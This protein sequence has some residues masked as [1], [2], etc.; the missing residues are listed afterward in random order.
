MSAV[1]GTVAVLAVYGI[2]RR[3]YSADTGLAAAA[4]FALLSPA[5]F[6]SRIAAYD[7]GAVMFLA[8]GLWLYVRGWQENK[9][10]LWLW[11]AVCFFAAFVCKYILALSF[12]F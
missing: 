8:V 10:H 11:A 2:T 6:S 7:S 3:V 4:I 12:S 1:A 9:D 5:V